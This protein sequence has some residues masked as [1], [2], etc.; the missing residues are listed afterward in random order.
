MRGGDGHGAGYQVRGLDVHKETITVAVADG[1]GGEARS[2]GTI[3]N[4]PEA[5]AR[6][7]RKLG[8]PGRLVCCYEA[9]PCGYG[10]QRQLTALGATCQV[11]APSLVP[12]R[13]GDRVKTD[14]RDALKLARLLRSGELTAVWVPEAAHEAVRDLSRAR[15]DARE[16]LQR[17][18]QRLGKLLLRLGVHPP[19]G[20][21]AWTKRHAA[22]L[23][24]VRLPHPPQQVVLGEYRL[25][26]TQAHERLKRLEGELAL[27]AEQG[28]HAAVLAAL[29]TCRGVGLI[30]ATTLVAELGDLRRFP[31]PRELMKYVGVVPSEASSGG[32]QRRGPV[33]KTG[34]RHVRHVI[35]EAAWH[36]RYPPRLAGLLKRRQ[37]GQP[38]AVQ[39]I[40]WKA[41]G[42]LHGRY[43]RLLARGKSKG[44]VIVA[45]AR[46]L[47]GFLW[48][49]AQQVAP[50]SASGLIATPA[51]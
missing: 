12:T 29:Q 9:G 37:A 17:A 8:G 31:S 48:A 6:L 2:V 21:R 14:R 41:Q 43:R 22:W 27:A 30:T 35:V 10:L 39:A 15:G 16:D 4:Q 13:P 38:E 7:V 23:D 51:A 32:R 24:T 5:V 11:V 26:V 40:A 45:L 33:T 25:A 50:A 44:T 3:R 36:Y 19:A 49:I 34:N 20:V 1:R 42:R 46:E 47:L 18:R 28:P